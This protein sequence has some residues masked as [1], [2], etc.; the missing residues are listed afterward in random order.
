MDTPFSPARIMVLMSVEADYQVGRVK[1]C[2]AC[3]GLQLSYDKFQIW[4]PRAPPSANNRVREPV[5]GERM[6][7]RNNSLRISCGS[8]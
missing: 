7:L 1:E 5:A 4:R 2:L 6:P 3:V 8:R